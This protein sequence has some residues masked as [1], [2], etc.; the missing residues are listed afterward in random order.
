M[1]IYIYLPNYW[2]K[3]MLFSYVFLTKYEHAKRLNMHEVILLNNH[4]FIFGSICNQLR[5]IDQ[6]YKSI[7]I[8]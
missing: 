3:H 2:Y 7:V 6:C 8:F 5:N 4:F 1:C